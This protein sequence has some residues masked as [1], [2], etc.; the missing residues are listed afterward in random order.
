[1]QFSMRGILL[2]IT[3]A[4]VCAAGYHLSEHWGSRATMSSLVAFAAICG[5]LRLRERAGAQTR[6]ESLPPIVRV[7]SGVLLFVGCAE[8]VRA[9]VC[10]I[11]AAVRREP[12]RP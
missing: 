3:V 10:L 8:A 9:V 1:M 2:F 6:P 4:A 7:L 11:L 12:F 5:G